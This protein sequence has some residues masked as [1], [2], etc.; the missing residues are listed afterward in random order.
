MPLVLDA[1]RATPQQPLAHGIH[2]NHITL[3]KNDIQ[4]NK[5][6]YNILFYMNI[7]IFL[8]RKYL[9]YKTIL[10]SVINNI[11]T[12]HA[13]QPAIHLAMTLQQV[14]D[15]ALSKVDHRDA[16]SMAP[17]VNTRNQAMSSRH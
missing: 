8:I 15:C 4:S 14:R 12:L 1:D 16:Q 13:P 7:S 2:N 3:Y 5:K 6:I 17:D 9:I 10:F 11:L